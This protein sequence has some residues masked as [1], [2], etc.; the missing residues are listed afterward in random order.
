MCKD[1]SQ[2][3]YLGV[4]GTCTLCAGTRKITFE[5][6]AAFRLLAP[7]IGAIDAVIKLHKAKLLPKASQQLV[8]QYLANS[9]SL[10]PRRT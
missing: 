8:R 10:I 6:D 9:S 7:N 1:N 3:G 5:V 2:V 4:D